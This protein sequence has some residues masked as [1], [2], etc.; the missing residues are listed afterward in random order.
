M[1]LSGSSIDPLRN[2]TNKAV[3][4]IF[5]NRDCPISNRY[6]PEFRRLDERFGKL[7]FKFILVYPDPDD[8]AEVIR[9]HTNEF[10][11]T[12]GILRDPDHWLVKKAKASVT[13]EASVFVSNARLVYHGRIDNRQVAFG[14]ERPQATEHDLEDVLQAISSGKPL[15]VT[16]KPAIGC[17]IPEH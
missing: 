8:S 4:L 11:L 14:R 15:A 6:A 3:V 16:S 1:D 5:V 7:G 13:P 10:Q 12:M 2:I 17:Y 9:Q